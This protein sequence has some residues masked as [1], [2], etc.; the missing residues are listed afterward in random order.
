MIKKLNLKDHK[1]AVDTIKIFHDSYAIEAEILKAK[2]FPP[3]KRTMSEYTDTE[4]EFYGHYTQQ[5][6]SAVI[7]IKIEEKSIHIQSLVVDPS[8]FRQGIAIKLLNFVLRNFETDHFSVE[9]GVDNLPA[10][11][12]YKKLG[13]V[14]VNQYDTNHGIRKIRLKNTPS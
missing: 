4:T 11:K 9:T 14:E 5:I 2:D 3:L 1:L 6:L 12:L 7:E 8:F 13:F 10:I